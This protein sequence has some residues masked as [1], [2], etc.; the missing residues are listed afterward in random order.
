MP[1]TETYHAGSEEVISARRLVSPLD[2]CPSVA[3]APFDAQTVRVLVDAYP[4]SVA[5]VLRCATGEVEVRTLTDRGER[6]AVYSAAVGAPVAVAHLEELVA[7]GVRTFVFFGACGVLDAG[8]PAADLVVPTAAYRDEGTSYHYAPASDWI[9]VRT[10]GRLQGW[11]AELGV[12]FVAGKV[13]TTD[14]FYRETRAIVDRRIEQGCVAVDMECSALAAA[15]QLRGVDVYQFFYAADNLDAD[16]WDQ[17]VL[18]RVADQTRL[19]HARVALEVAHRAAA[20]DR[21]GR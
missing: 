1:I 10:S 17:R 12:G 19:A 21:A 11:L 5:T 16:E 18:G 2:G 6:F 14:G 8:I 7:L 3:V 15:A 9:D 4:T 13:W 20:L